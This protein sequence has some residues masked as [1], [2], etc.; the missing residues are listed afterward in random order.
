VASPQ[1]VEDK[2]A[3]LSHIQACSSTGHLAGNPET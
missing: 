2:A 1:M 3:A